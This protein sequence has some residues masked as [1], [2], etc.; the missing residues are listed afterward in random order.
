MGL[1][2]DEATWPANVLSITEAQSW[3][4]GVLPGNPEVSGPTKVYAAKDDFGVTARFSVRPEGEDVVLKANVYSGFNGAAFAFDVLSRHCPGNVPAVIAWQDDE[5]RSRILTRPFEGQALS[6][7]RSTAALQ[8]MAGTVGR[9]QA[10]IAVLPRMETARVPSV[11]VKR[12]ITLFDELLEDVEANQT[13]VWVAGNQKLSEALRFPAE[14]LPSRLRTLRPEV[15]DWVEELHA[16]DWPSTICHGD[17]HADNAVLQKD[18]RVLVYDW[19]DAFLSCPFMCLERLLVQA[20]N[21]DAGGDSVGPWGYVAGTAG[22]VAVQDAYVDALPFGKTA[23]RRRACAVAMC[24]AVIREAYAEWQWALS[25]GW[26]DGN[27]E[28]TAQLMNRL[29]QHRDMIDVRS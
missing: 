12:I 4:S 26:P 20:W 16:Q 1:D 27:P 8:E 29:L 18:G 2:N 13:T 22:Q 10:T 25:L 11:P 24:L 3:I 5:G 28:W 9:I 23:S 17:L 15:V 14:E 7:L 19:E 21:W 6:A